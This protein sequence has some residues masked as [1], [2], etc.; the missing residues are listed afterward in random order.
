MPRLEAVGKPILA[1]NCQDE[2]QK[3][4]FMW[5]LWHLIGASLFLPL[6]VVVAHSPVRGYHSALRRIIPHPSRRRIPILGTRSLSPDSALCR[7]RSPPHPRHS[8]LPIFRTLPSP[9]IRT[10]GAMV[11]PRIVSTDVDVSCCKI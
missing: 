5:L 8:V 2:N 6:H 9:T 11:Y 4:K 10:Y 7:T 1:G 3:R